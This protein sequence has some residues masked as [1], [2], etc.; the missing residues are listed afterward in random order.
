MLVDEEGEKVG[1]DG[2]ERG[3]DGDG[4]EESLAAVPGDDAF[5]LGCG[6]FCFGLGFVFV[7]VERNI[8]GC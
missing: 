5:V 3:E 1:V 8:C 7:F 6:V 2:V 4:E